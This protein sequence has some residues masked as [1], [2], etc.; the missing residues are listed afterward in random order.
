MHKKLLV[1][2]GLGG[3]SAN[4][5]MP[6]VVRV[7]SELSR[8]KTSRLLAAFFLLLGLTGLFLGARLWLGAPL[9][10]GDGTCKAI[11]GLTMLAATAFGDSLGHVIG[12]AL[13]TGVG[14]A[15]CIVSVTIA[16]RGT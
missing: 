14:L 8:V 5:V 13:W 16:R 11:C 2:Q 12:G 7:Y 4:G 9:P 3:K 15:F 10:N 1:R 6:W